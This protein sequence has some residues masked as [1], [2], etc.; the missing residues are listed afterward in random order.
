MKLLL[1]VA[2]PYASGPRHIG[3][4]AGAYIPADIFA[5]YHRMVGNDVL[6]VSGSDMHGTP[7]TVRADEEGVSTEV[8]AERYH[9]MHTKNFEQLGISYDLYWKTSADNHKAAVQEIFLRLKER[10]HIYEDTMDSSWCP[11]C[12]RYRPDRYVEG[13]CPH[14]HFPQSRGDQCENC[15]RMLDP[16]ELIHPRCKVCGTHIERRET[17]HYFF[18]L[19]AFQ[20]PLTEWL[21]T[22]GYWRAHVLNFAL[23]WLQEGLKDRPVTR[24]IDWG[25]AVPVEGYETKRI[26]VWFEAV[27]GYLTT[28]MEWA[29]RQGDREL[30]KAWWLD[31]DARH[32]Y[33]VGKDNIVFHTIIWPAI[34]MGYDEALN[35]PYDVPANQYMNFAGEKMSSGRGVGVWLPELL[36]AYDP[37]A[38]R[39]YVSAS[40]PENKDSEFT[41]REL[42]RRIN[43]ELV[44]IY[45]N[46]V[47]RVLTFTH[48]NFGEIP[49]ASSMRREDEALLAEMEGA[50]KR[51]GQNL[52]YCH[53]KEALKEVMGLARKG[54]QYFDRMAPWDLIKVDREACG[55]ALHMALR[56]VRALAIMTAPFLPFSADRLWRMLGFE[57]DVHKASWD[58]ALGELS[59]GQP[60]AAPVPL[61]SKIE[62]PG[63]NLQDEA[64]RLDVRVGRVL[65]VEDHPKA[66]KLYLVDVDLGTEERRL[67]A[68]IK[69]QYDVKEIQGR[70]IV[71]LCNLKP[72]TLRGIESKG[73]LLAAVDGD[74]VSL[75]LAGKVA[76]GTRVLGAAE[77]PQISFEDFRN[78]KMKVDEKGKV[79]FF[80]TQEGD[81]IPLK[82]GQT[83]V[84]VDRPVRAGS[85]VT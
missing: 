9:A 83:E 28:S 63:L 57:G 50:W 60:L 53:F 2:W 14:C 37:D 55:T 7:A 74:Q 12:E 17:R 73:M 80:G 6:M 41:F 5:R 42:A 8:V 23:S 47:H 40:M 35:L 64:Q 39:Y 58:D 4:V 30:W 82:A 19:T 43:T 26:Y 76:P 85:E 38:L 78:L 20:E 13:E 71:V 72:A 62:E 52:D 27:M 61:F 48:K 77:A 1:G 66:D 75:L 44:A 15:G 22:K 59:P 29:R 84:T 68:G 49:P 45:G 79:R 21:R 34:L 54:N 81:S 65:N 51:T 67:V 70:N 11:K 16:F 36:G 56:L 31:P 46:F 25:I 33:F 3:H 32:Y 69:D 10:G 18:R 24:D